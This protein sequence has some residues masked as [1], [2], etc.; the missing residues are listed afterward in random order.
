VIISLI[1]QKGG[2]GKTTSCLNLGASL[3]ALGKRILLIDLDPQYNLT[4]ILLKEEPEQSIYS[5]YN[6]EVDSLSKIINELDKFDLITSDIRLAGIE[7][8]NDINNYFLLR[9]ELKKLNE[10][11]DYIL[12]DCPPSLGVMTMSALIAS[13]FLIIPVK[14]EFLSLK[15]IEQLIETFTEIRKIHNPTLAIMGVLFTM[16][17]KRRNLD[18]E[19]VKSIDY[20]PVLNTIIRKNV[21]VAESPGAFQPISDYNPNSV[22][23]EDYLNLAKEIMNHE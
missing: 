18:R 16:F 13:N 20:L 21:D 14:T 4:S 19:I 5:F 1:N 10:N 6:K 7:R 17:E 11:Y 8:R 2:V 12:I 22:G 23:A 3:A 9:E 15:G